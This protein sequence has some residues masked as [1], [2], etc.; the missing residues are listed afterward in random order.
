[1]SAGSGAGTPWH[2]WGP[3]PHTPGLPDKG[4]LPLQSCDARP[5]LQPWETS[6]SEILPKT[7]PNPLRQAVWAVLTFLNWFTCFRLY[8]LAQ[9]NVYVVFLAPKEGW[10]RVPQDENQG[11]KQPAGSTALRHH[12]V[13]MSLFTHANFINIIYIFKAIY[14]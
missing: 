10:G 5:G 9:F 2:S 12:L 6:N 1:M 13:I 7:Q 3:Q 8:F 14:K 4:L 11:S